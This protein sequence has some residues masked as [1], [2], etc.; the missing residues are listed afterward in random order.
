[1]GAHAASVVL[2]V[3]LGVAISVVVVTVA[4]PATGSTQV[5]LACM[6]NVTSAGFE[7]LGS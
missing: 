1:M 2:F 4:T 3:Y 6:P 5:L 7:V